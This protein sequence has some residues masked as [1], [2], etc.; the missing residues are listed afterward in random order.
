[1]AISDKVQPPP[2]IVGGEELVLDAVR[3]VHEPASGEVMAHVPEATA[4]RPTRVGTTR[5]P[6][7]AERE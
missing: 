4:G 1:M 3:P 6:S 2:I 5:C 7:R